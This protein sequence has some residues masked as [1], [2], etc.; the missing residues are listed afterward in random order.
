LRKVELISFLV[1]GKVTEILY[2]TNQV[3]ETY[4]T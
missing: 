4:D 1:I 3:Y 2:Y